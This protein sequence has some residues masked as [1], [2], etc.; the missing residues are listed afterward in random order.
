MFKHNYNVNANTLTYMPFNQSNRVFSLGWGGEI[1]VCIAL[2]C[3]VQKF[4]YANEWNS[5]NISLNFLEQN[6]VNIKLGKLRVRNM[7]NEVQ[8]QE[9]CKS[10]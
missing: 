5:T 9:K 10:E 3:K 6:D 7:E 8:L 4:S 2:S 1:S